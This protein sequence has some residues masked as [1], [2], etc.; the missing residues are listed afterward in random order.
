MAVRVTGPRVISSRVAGAL[1]R[2]S[3]IRKMFEHGA[4]LKAQHGAENV[5]D[6]S[7]G[8]PSFEPPIEVQQRLIDLATRPDDFAQP[9]FTTHGYM[10]NAGYPAVRA[11]VAEH[12][13]RVHFPTT[14][15]TEDN[16]LMTCGAG[17]AL[18]VIFKAILDPGDKVVVP[19]PYFVE[20]GFYVDN[21]QGTLVPVDTT[22]DF[23]LDLAK[24][25]AAID[26][27]TRAI[28]IDSPNNPTGAVYSRES[29]EE[30]QQ[31]IQRKEEEL[32]TI[33]YLLSDEP[34]RQLAYDG[35]EV[36]PI[37]EIFP[38][39]IVAYSFSKDLSLAGQRIG[40][41][42]VNPENHGPET[43]FG[44]M[45]FANRILGFVNPVALMQRLIVDMHD[46]VV[47]VDELKAR[48]DL[49][50]NKLVG[51][52]YQVVKPQGAFYLF[53]QSPIKDDV[54]FCQAAA[55]KLSLV[56][57]GTG[58]GRGAHFRISYSSISMAQIER[59]LP[60]FEGL[61][62]DFGI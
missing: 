6:F 19:S 39:S 24:I 61:A 15:L 46:L 22:I 10:P 2:A 20:Y 56:V 21:H 28:L 23:Q 30:L 48:R 13:N 47:G 14:P 58:F 54:E 60:I 62:Q 35:V 43:L 59:A 50:Y 34:Y 9:G 17:G 7:L 36:P 45:S 51:M 8:N 5:F 41:I 57:P 29:L 49:L 27:D 32:G 37:F 25:E 42:G 55:E 18:N 12:L 38:R 31:L 40:Y 4:K 53:P 3:W 26:A 33:I 1:D 52:G 44:A 16:V 11:N